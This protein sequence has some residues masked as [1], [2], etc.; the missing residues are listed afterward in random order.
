MLERYQNRLNS[1][2]TK[3]DI[4]AGKIPYHTDHSQFQDIDLKRLQFQHNITNMIE[5]LNIFKDC[6][7]NHEH[8]PS[9]ISNHSNSELDILDKTIKALTN[10]LH[11]EMPDRL[12]DLEIIQGEIHFKNHKYD[13]ALQ[14]WKKALTYSPCNQA[15]H[16]RLEH[17]A[18]SNKYHDKF[19][20][21]HRDYCFKYAGSFGHKILK[22]A[23]KII[24][25][26]PDNTIF[27]SD[28]IKNVIHRFDAQ[29][30][31]T[32][33][34]FADLNYPFGLFT[35]RENNLWICDMKN[36][37]LICCNQDG[38]ILRQINLQSLFQDQSEYIY[39]LFGCIY[40]G[41]IYLRCSN[42]FFNKA[43]MIR[44]NLND[45]SFQVVDACRFLHIED[46][47]KVYDDVLYAHD[48][49]SGILY[50]YD[51]QRDSFEIALT[52]KPKGGFRHFVK[53]GTCFFVCLDNNI[54]KFSHSGEMIFSVAVSRALNNQRFMAND[55]E[56]VTED[57]RGLLLITDDRQKCIH[58]FIIYVSQ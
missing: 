3:L 58:K 1:H 20:H 2:L 57:D 46:D 49:H 37:R 15:I 27:V 21:L 56:I 28:H 48:Y 18:E 8:T 53:S 38:K 12:L 22:Q 36:S 45:E 44:L 10:Y 34:I 17:I 4:P 24:S 50:T 23:G 7:K 47:L 51:F 16:D 32:G 5:D 29:G 9:W 19:M 39:P 26:L 33:T 35:D 42:R 25:L 13:Q 55:I 14:A 52:V 31:H 40:H 11:F 30:D 43:I 6:I 54:L 41:A